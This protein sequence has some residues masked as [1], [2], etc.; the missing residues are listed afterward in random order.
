MHYKAV[1]NRCAVDFSSLLLPVTTERALNILAEE[2]I[3]PVDVDVISLARELVGKAE[4]LWAA[5]QWQAPA[6]FDCS[7]FTKWLYG[8][9]GIW[10]PRRPQQQFEFC[11]LIQKNSCYF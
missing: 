2:N 6:L 8:Q 3:K 7:S 1:G 9:M 5:R 10:I 4:W 11:E